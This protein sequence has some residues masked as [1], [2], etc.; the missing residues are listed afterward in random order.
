M[1]G[2]GAPGPAP[3]LDSPSRCVQTGTA[4]HPPRGGRFPPRGTPFTPIPPPFDRPHQLT[5]MLKATV[6]ALALLAAAVNVRVQS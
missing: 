3:A 6:L 4:G 1:D 2:R 5:T